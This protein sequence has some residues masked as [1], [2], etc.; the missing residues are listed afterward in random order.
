MSKPV[1]LIFL[2]GAVLFSS[3]APAAEDLQLNPRLHYGSNRPDGPLITGSDMERGLVTG[4]PNYVIIYAER[5]FN[6]KRQARRT[7]S[8]YEKY[9]GRVNF[10]IIDLDRKRSPAQREVVRK[11]FKKYLPQV[12]VTDQQESAVYNQAG[13]VEE[14]TISGILDAALK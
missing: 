9:R 3:A 5:S 12:V 8:L 4:K 6:C 10:V 7:V 13:E 11:Y 2:A 14:R 1:A